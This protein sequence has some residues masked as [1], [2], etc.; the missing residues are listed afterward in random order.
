MCPS[1]PM[2]HSRRLRLLVLLMIVWV[3]PLHAARAGETAEDT[4][5]LEQAERLVEAWPEEPDALDRAQRMVDEVLGRNPAA[6]DGHRL[7]AMILM[8]NGYISGKDYA[9]F[10]LERA[11]RSVDKAIAMS[12]DND[13]AYVLRANIY[14]LTARADMARRDLERAESLAPDN[15]W[16]QFV[17]ADLLLAEK[18]EDAAAERCREGAKRRPQDLHVQAY[19]NECLIGYHRRG[20]RDAE[21]EKLYREQ[22]A[23]EPTRAWSLGN[24]AGFLMCKP[25]RYD[26]AVAQARATIALMNYG[27]VNR[28]LATALYRRWAAQVLAGQTA[29]AEQTWIEARA[30]GQVDVAALLEQQCGGQPLYDVMLA[31]RATGRARLYSPEQAIPLAIA[32]HEDGGRTLPGV[33]LMQVQATGRSDDSVFLNSMT[34][35]RDP[36]CLTLRFGPKAIDAF[37]KQYGVDPEVYYRGRTVTVVGV[38]FR[39]KIEIISATATA[40]SHYFQTQISV[41]DLEQIKTIEQM[42]QGLDKG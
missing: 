38:A 26:D 29:A 1:L 37:R 36:R 24:Y 14:H 13:R 19:A 28:T 39:L 32:A 7:S 11:E 22:I 23:R 4:Q 34:D 9:P 17:W 5:A 12:P 6:S 10:A 31:L 16:V 15:P 21:A 18:K 33:F 20:G 41:S 3:L 35:Y 27:V 42:P 40:E 2:I 25:E 8:R 30:I